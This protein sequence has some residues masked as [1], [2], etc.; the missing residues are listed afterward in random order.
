MRMPFPGV[1]P[2]SAQSP[3]SPFGKGS[4]AQKAGTPD[5]GPFGPA[6]RRNEPSGRPFSSRPGSSGSARYRD[7][8]RKGKAP[9]D[10]GQPEELRYPLGA[11]ALDGDLLKQV[12][13]P[14][15]EIDALA[16]LARARR[17]RCRVAQPVELMQQQIK[18]I[19]HELV[20]KS[21]I[22]ARARK[23]R[24]GY[25]A[26]VGHAGSAGFRSCPRD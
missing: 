3:S 8:A 24:I 2:I 18:V 15:C 10:A 6:A 4:K 9:R 13:E 25:R 7:F 14:D 21:R 17:V 5:A 20:P 23:V 26:K 1:V 19:G 22:L 16:D 11:R 12:R